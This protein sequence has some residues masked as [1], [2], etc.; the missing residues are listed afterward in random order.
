[1][2]KLSN[3]IYNWLHNLSLITSL[4]PKNHK[5]N[6]KKLS[7]Q[8]SKK[9]KNGEILL[10]LTKKILKKEGKK[11]YEKNFSKKKNLKSNWENVEISI[12]NLGIFINPKKKE[13]ILKGNIIPIKEI[14]FK[15]NKKFGENFQ[16]EEKENKKKIFYNKKNYETQMYTICE[17]NSKNVNFSKFGKN[18]NSFNII[19]N[20]NSEISL[21]INESEKILK[22]QK[23]SKI[24]KSQIWSNSSISQNSEFSNLVKKSKIVLN[25]INSTKFAILKNSE[26]KNYKIYTSSYLKNS[27]KLEKMDKKFINKEY[28]IQNEVKNTLSII[29]KNSK[30]EKSK[31]IFEL[32]IVIISKSFDMEPIYVISLFLNNNEIFK[33]LVKNGE[34]NF[35]FSRIWIFVKNL[36]C[37]QNTIFKMFDFGERSLK[38]IFLFFDFLETFFFCPE[39]KIF[40]TFS[41]FLMN[42]VDFLKKN[43]MCKIFRKYLRQ[44]F[45]F[46]KKIIFICQKNNFF[47]NKF[48][49]ILIKLGK[50]NSFLYEI[51]E[52]LTKSEKR[53]DFFFLINFIFSEN[54]K[55]LEFCEKNKEF[56]NFLLIKT[57]Q[58]FFSYK[59]SIDF[60]FETKNNF[61]EKI[62]FC[63]FFQSVKLLINLLFIK[64]YKLQNNM[65]NS[66]LQKL[67]FIFQ[68][69]NEKNNK[70]NLNKKSKINEI[71]KIQLFSIIIFLYKN[72]QNLNF[73]IKIF[74][75]KFFFGIILNFEKEN[76]Y[77]KK[78]IITFFFFEENKNNFLDFKEKFFI[79]I[80]WIF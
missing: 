5:N 25:P 22:I 51:L 72:F 13:E 78:M 36:I 71:E 57:T 18:S 64:K 66:F 12:K 10:S 47:Y 29:N 44:N 45:G 23:N 2:I 38:D 68:N 32:L 65:I 41:K 67:I 28:I 26:K 4:P 74:L 61:I 46:I 19:K 40:L 39:K 1:M 8:D 62:N 43:N 50:K 9:L 11:N 33:E 77:F 20:S 17:E 52:I 69:E 31:N 53:L 58:V 59:I 37:Y 30:I 56:Y 6:I 73:E 55:I 14:L 21:K 79:I 3:E 70:W 75:E 15:L 24:A 16:I 34:K 54:S 27:Q 7:L 76:I 48:F 42:L 60:G 35:N 80:F 63:E 49:E